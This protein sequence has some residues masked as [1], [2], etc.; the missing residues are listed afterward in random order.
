M[1][2]VFAGIFTVMLSMDKNT[3]NIN[4]IE[5]LFAGV[6]LFF[7]FGFVKSILEL[8]KKDQQQEKENRKG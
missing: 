7:A 4:K 5:M 8:R 6:M 1:V 2:L 3:E